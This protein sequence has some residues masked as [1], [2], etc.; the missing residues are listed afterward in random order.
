MAASTDFYCH[1]VVNW[2]S[3]TFKSVSVQMSGPPLLSAG[4]WSTLKLMVALGDVIVDHVSAAR[5][6]KLL[7][8]QP[9]RGEREFGSRISCFV[10]FLVSFNIF[11][12]LYHQHVQGGEEGV[13]ERQST[14]VTCTCCQN[15]LPDMELQALCKHWCL[16]IALLPFICTDGGGLKSWSFAEIKALIWIHPVELFH[17]RCGF[18]FLVTLDKHIDF[19]I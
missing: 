5:W 17:H 1:L 11:A 2:L 7:P 8:Q 14:N 15:H 9:G 19:L 10:F 18:Y 12:E 16:K 13:M 4:R 6:W 3:Y